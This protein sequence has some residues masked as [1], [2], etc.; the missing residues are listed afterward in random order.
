M[1]EYCSGLPCPPPGMIH[2]VGFDKCVLK[3][4][5][6]C[7]HTYTHTHTHTHIHTHTHTSL[8]YNIYTSLY[9]IMEQFDCT[10]NALCCIYSLLSLHQC[11]ST[12]NLLKISI[13]LCFPECY[14]VGTILYIAFSGWLPLYPCAAVF[15]DTSL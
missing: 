7:T 3:Y 9:Y 8:Y 11:A 14:I 10:K 1:K 15:V 5:Y 2:S 6:I 13:S 4:I 12:T